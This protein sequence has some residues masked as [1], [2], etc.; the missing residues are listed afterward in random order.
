M[1]SQEEIQE[2]LLALRDHE[3]EQEFEIQ[4]TKLVTN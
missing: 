4:S 1:I 2:K 3:T